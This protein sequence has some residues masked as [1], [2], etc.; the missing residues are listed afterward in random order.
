MLNF[1]IQGRSRIEKRDIQGFR[2]IVVS[3]FVCDDCGRAADEVQLAGQFGSQGLR[4]TLQV[5]QGCSTT[6]NRQVL[7]SDTATIRYMPHVWMAG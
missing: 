4:L 1:I 7:K 5:P 3:Q 2:E 6:L